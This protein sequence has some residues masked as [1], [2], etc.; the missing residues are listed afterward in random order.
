MRVVHLSRAGVSLVVG[1]DD[2]GIPSVLHWG[3]ALGDLDDDALAG[4]LAARRPGVSRSSYDVPRTTGLVP[5]GTRGFAGTPALEGHRVGGSAT[6]AAP[7]LVDW[8]VSG[9][10]SA[11]TCTATDPEAGWDVTVQLALDDGGL[12]HAR[13]SVTNAADGDLHLSAVLTALPV[14]AHATRAA[15]PDRALVQGTLAPAAP[16]GA[17]H[18]PPRR[19]PRPHRPRRDPPDGLRHTRLHLRHRRGL[20]G[21][22]RVERQPHDVRRAHP[23]G[24]LPARRRRAARPGRGG[25]RPRRH[26]PLPLAPRVVVARRARPAEPPLPRAP[27]GRHAPRAHRASRHRQHLGGGLLRPVA[28]AAVGARRRRRLGRGRAVRRSTTA[29]S[30]A[31][32]T[33]PPGSATG[34]ST[35]PSGP[36]VSGRWS[37]T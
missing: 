31:A 3:A 37:S 10:D 14:G 23:R 26:L 28:R 32:A 34:P 35:R 22:H 8:E 7:S 6:A 5:D 16:V 1:R 4:L 20:G 33:T 21:P 11:L 24:R 36:T 12:L 2:L 9:G 27:A 15:R 17:G 19:P 25:A 13:T 18:A 30:S 29:G